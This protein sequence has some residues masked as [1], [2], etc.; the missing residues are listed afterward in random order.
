MINFIVVDDVKYFLDEVNSIITNIMMKNTAEYKIYSFNEY[1][2]NFTKVSNSSIPNKVY[3]LDIETKLH[4]GIDV[5]RKIRIKDVNS[6]LIFLTAHDELSSIVSKDQLMALTFICKFDDF[7]TNIEKAISKSL[8]ILNQNT[9][10]R[11]KDYGTVY[12]LDINDILYITRDTVD[13]KCVIKTDYG[14]YKVGKTLTE[15]KELCLDR[16]KQTHRGCLVNKDRVI[17]MDSKKN[18]IVF[19]NGEVI[20]LISATY[21]KGMIQC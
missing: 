6:V 7:K 8:T 20:N 19:D 12:T 15:L 1:D 21:K 2:S 10:I 14:S 13:R 4:S 18:E 3:I 9:V 17:K 11:F 16:L 5:A